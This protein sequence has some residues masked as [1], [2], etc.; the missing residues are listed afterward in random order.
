L[1]YTVNK[2]IFCRCFHFG[3]TWWGALTVF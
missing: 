3:K 2:R 1:T